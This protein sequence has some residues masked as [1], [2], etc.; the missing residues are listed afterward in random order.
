MSAPSREAAE[1]AQVAIPSTP[2]VDCADCC[3]HNHSDQTPAGPPMPGTLP[4]GPQATPPAPMTPDVAP[5]PVPGR[6]RHQAH[7]RWPDQLR[8]TGVSAL[9]LVRGLVLTFAVGMIAWSVLPAAFGWTT[10][11]VVTGSMAPAI[12]VGDI[13]GAAPIERERIDKLAP[14]TVLLM[15]DPAKPGKLLLHRLVGKTAD[16]NLVTKGDANEE[17]DSTA[18]PQ[19]SVRGV[20]RLRVPAIGLPVL[21]AQHKHY[22]PL[23]ALGVLMVTIVFWRPRRSHEL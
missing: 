21:W 7:R 9:G 8:D 23:A 19:E 12:R 5:P 11:V 13:V 18:V 15:D 4:P 10:S 14:G 22:V 6:G 17:A 1:A 20:A 16:G 3:S 2:V